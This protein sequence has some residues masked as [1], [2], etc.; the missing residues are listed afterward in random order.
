MQIKVTEVSSHNLRFRI[1]L[2]NSDRRNLTPEVTRFGVYIL[3]NEQTV[4]SIHS[5]RKNFHNIR[6][7]SSITD[8]FSVYLVAYLF[9]LAHKSRN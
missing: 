6:S 5:T 7:A 2:V 1:I 3:S 4:C 9:R 8:L